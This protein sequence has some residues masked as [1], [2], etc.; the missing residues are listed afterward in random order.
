MFAYVTTGRTNLSDR[1][2]VQH[3]FSALCRLVGS[4]HARGS[5]RG[6]RDA[7]R[8]VVGNHRPRQ[9]R[10]VRRHREDV[11]TFVSDGRI[12]DTVRGRAVSRQNDRTTSPVSASSP[13]FCCWRPAAMNRAVHVFCPWPKAGCNAALTRSSWASPPRPSRSPSRARCLT[14]RTIPADPAPSVHIDVHGAGPARPPAPG[15]ASGQRI[16]QTGSAV[17]SSATA[18]A[19]RLVPGRARRV[20]LHAAGSRTVQR[21]RLAH[22]RPVPAAPN[23]GKGGRTVAPDPAGI[24]ISQASFS[25]G[26]AMNSTAACWASIT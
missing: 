15:G 7:P 17:T 12:M 8:H 21:K 23:N 1:S 19:T 3:S 14:D 22:G 5:R 25:A 2:F 16:V 9:G 24:K 26:V 13:P 11:C 20:P 4:H 6:H 18:R 10:P